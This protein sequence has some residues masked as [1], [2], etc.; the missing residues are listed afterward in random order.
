MHGSEN[1]VPRFPQSMYDGFVKFMDMYD[2]FFASTNCC[3]VSGS[4]SVRLTFE[5]RVT[6]WEKVYSTFRI[7]M[8]GT[9]L[10]F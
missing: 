7:G 5:S 9:P 4:Y 6:R 10:H 8:Q 2:R 3:T 1:S